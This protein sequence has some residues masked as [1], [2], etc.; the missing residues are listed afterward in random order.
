MRVTKYKLG[1]EPFVND[2]SIRQ[3]NDSQGEPAYMLAILV[4]VLTPGER[5]PLFPPILR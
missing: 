5:A 2:V 1:G 4:P 3:L